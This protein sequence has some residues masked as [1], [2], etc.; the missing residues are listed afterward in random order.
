MANGRQ[1][2]GR[3]SARKALTLCT[4]ALTLLGFSEITAALGHLEHLNVSHNRLECVPAAIGS[5]GSLQTLN[6]SHNRISEI[7][8]D[9]SSCSLMLHLDLSHN[10]LATL[11]SSLSQVGPLHEGAIPNR[12]ARVP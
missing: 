1:P 2:V 7:A 12:S 6:A 4:Q 5:L 10:C 11:P 9:L 8:D 3:F